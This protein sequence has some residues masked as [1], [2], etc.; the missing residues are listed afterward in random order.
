[1]KGVT[2]RPE[3]CHV[4]PCVTLGRAGHVVCHVG[5][6]V[7]V[8]HPRNSVTYGVTLVNVTDT[9]TPKGCPCHVGRLEK[10]PRFNGWLALWFASPHPPHR[11]PAC[12]LLWPVFVPATHTIGARTRL[13]CRAHIDHAPLHSTPCA[14]TQRTINPWHAR[15]PLCRAARFSAGHNL[16]IPTLSR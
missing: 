10:A 11:G 13:R 6:H 14:L 12:L 1:M 9:P 2:F 15:K 4:T 16:V 3:T 7:S 8:T 5:R